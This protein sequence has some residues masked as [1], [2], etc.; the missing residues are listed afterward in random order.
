MDEDYIRALEYG[1][2]PTGGEGIGIDRLVML[3][4]NSP[5]IRDVIL[6]PLMRPQRLSRSRRRCRY[7]AGSSPCRYLLAR[8]KQAF[9]SLISLVSML[10]VDRR[11][12]GAG[13]RAGADD[14]AAG[15]AARPDPRARRRTSTSARPAASPTTGRGRA[16]H[17][18]CRGVRRRRAG[19]A[20]QGAGQHAA[21]S[22][23]SSRSRA[24]TRRSSAQVTEIARGDAPAAA[25][26]RSTSERRRRA[27]R[28][29]A[30]PR[31]GRRS[32]ARSSA[33]WSRC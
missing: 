28:H 18:R 6:F 25:S 19:A 24:S 1:L 12:D 26:R 32:S 13:H 11:R 22:R 8:R 4:T 33:T 9:I 15:G 30:R 20:G 10:G 7:R 17:A 23:R 3:L 31:A 29:R 27:A 2:P 5:S 14:R 16:A 21:T